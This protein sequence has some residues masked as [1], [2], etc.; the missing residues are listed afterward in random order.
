VSEFFKHVNGGFS[1]HVDGDGDAITNVRFALARFG[2]DPARVLKAFWE[3]TQS[4]NFEVVILYAHGSPP[5]RQL[6]TQQSLASALQSVTLE[7]DSIVEKQ[8]KELAEHLDVACK[9]LGR[10][11]VAGGD[12]VPAEKVA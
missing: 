11:H 3:E 8:W 6:C 7:R 5:R 9:R 12:Q 10:L 2:E 4:G 1:M